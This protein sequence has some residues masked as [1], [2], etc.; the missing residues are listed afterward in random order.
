MNITLM[1]M[2]AIFEMPL[3]IRMRQKTQLEPRSPQSRRVE[4]MRG[5]VEASIAADV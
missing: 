4:E 1:V 5:K 3:L 2:L